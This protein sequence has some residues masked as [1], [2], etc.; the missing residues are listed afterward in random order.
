MH[1]FNSKQRQAN[2]WIQE[3]S[4]LHREFQVRH[5]ETLSQI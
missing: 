2:L 4:A 5:S 1:T 3:Q